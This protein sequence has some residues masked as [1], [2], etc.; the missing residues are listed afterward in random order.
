MVV[1]FEMKGMGVMHYF[2]GLEVLAKTR[3]DIP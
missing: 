2:L 3:G 1:E